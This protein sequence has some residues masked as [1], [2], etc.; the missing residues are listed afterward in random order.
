MDIIQDIALYVILAA[1]MAGLLITAVTGSSKGVKRLLIGLSVLFVIATGVGFFFSQGLL[2]FL[3]FQIIALVLAI[4][5]VIVAGAAVGGIVHS[6]MNKTGARKILQE[7]DLGDYVPAAEFALAAG[8]SE[9]RVLGRINSGYY[10]GGC[11]QGRWYVHKTE[12][13]SLQSVD[14]GK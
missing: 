13:A 10:R 2:I 8:T 1:F 9:E 6:S 7:T 5:I 4:Y 11:A 12:L 14:V 3:L